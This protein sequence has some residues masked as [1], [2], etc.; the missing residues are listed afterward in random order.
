[1][2]D[3]GGVSCR[4][5]PDMSDDGLCAAAEEIGFPVLLKPAAGGGGKGM[6]V[7]T[8][9]GELREQLAAARR[10][11]RA[12]F[13]DDSLLVERYVPQPR[14]IEVQVLGD[15]HGTVRH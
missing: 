13:G 8:A 1:S 10:E 5:D 2:S 11:S 3:S 14:H 6:R 4:S 7:V 9:E 15:Q 12:S